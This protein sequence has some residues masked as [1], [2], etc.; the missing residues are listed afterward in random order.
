MP[1]MFRALGG[2]PGSALQALNSHRHGGRN[3]CG[4]TE[5]GPLRLRELPET[6]PKC[7]SRL[8]VLERGVANAEQISEP[9]EWKAVSSRRCPEG[10]PLTFVDFP[11]AN[12]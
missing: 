10:C 1:E 12:R 9:T 7:G 5:D 6:C 3:L 11:D 4:V 8:L 2:L